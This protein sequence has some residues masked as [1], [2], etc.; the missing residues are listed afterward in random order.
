MSFTLERISIFPRLLV[1]SVTCSSGFPMD[2]SLKW[3]SLVKPIDTGT[4]TSGI[5][6]KN[7]VPSGSVPVMEM[8]LIWTLKIKTFFGFDLIFYGLFMATFWSFKFQIS[9]LFWILSF[10]SKH[11]CSQMSWLDED[12]IPW[13]TKHVLD[14]NLSR[15]IDP[16]WVVTCDDVNRLSWLSVE[17]L[18]IL[19][20]LRAGIDL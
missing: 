2:F 8:S 16:W 15:D 9:C 10:G 20:P 4:S 17:K 11:F 7:D 5:L 12:E 19:I 6:S 3:I 18:V 14:S 1:L 13:A